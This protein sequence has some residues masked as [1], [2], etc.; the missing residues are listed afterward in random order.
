MFILA[1][2]FD[3]LTP[4]GWVVT[5]VFGIASTIIIQRISRK[6]KQISW[7]LLS[8]AELFSQQVA[9]STSMPVKV[10]VGESENTSLSAVNMRIG[11]TGNEV[12][13]EVS[14]LIKFNDGAAIL[15]HEIENDLG[16]YGKNVCR[17]AQG[18]SLRIEFKFINP[19]QIIDLEILLGDY[20]PGSTQLDCAAPGVELRQQAMGRWDLSV[21]IFKSFAMGIAGIRYEPT[22]VPLIE[23]AETLRAISK[24]VDSLTTKKS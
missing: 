22:V 2:S 15:K 7:S 23:V 9:E 20:L 11:N 21:G 13:N 19:K 10:I 1:E 4:V 12:I 16:E 24:K 18:P 6:K 3:W 14:M 8:E 5:F 17:D